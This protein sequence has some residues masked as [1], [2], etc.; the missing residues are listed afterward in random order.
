MLQFFRHLDLRLVKVIVECNLN[1][2]FLIDQHYCIP[3]NLYFHH[4]EW[5]NCENLLMKY[6]S[7]FF[8]FQDLI[9]GKV[10]FGLLSYYLQVV[11][12]YCIPSNLS[13]HYQEWHKHERLLMI[14]RPPFF[15]FQ[16]SMLEPDHIGLC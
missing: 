3:N 16:D 5:H 13:T 7:L 1:N 2:L 15:Q 6:Q 9:S 12:C 8:R 10:Y 11:L 4:Q 14:L